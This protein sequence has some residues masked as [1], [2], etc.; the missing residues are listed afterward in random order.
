[1]TE[2]MTVTIPRPAKT[3]PHDSDFGTEASISDEV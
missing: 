1:M 2:Q 3:R